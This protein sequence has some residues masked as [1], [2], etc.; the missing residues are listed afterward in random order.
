MRP[1]KSENTNNDTNKETETMKP[2]AN[3]KKAVKE[4]NITFHTRLSKSY[5][6]DEPHMRPENIEAV[7]K[8]LKELK[9]ELK[10]TKMLDMGCGT[11]FMINIGKKLG[12]EE[13]HGYDITPAMIE[14][15]DKSGPAKIVTGLSDAASLPC[16]DESFDIATAYAFF[17]HLDEIKSVIHEAHRCL[18]KNGALYADLDPN[19][20][21]WDAVNGLDPKEHF[22][23]FVAREITHVSYKDD[24][25]QKQYGVDKEIFNLAEYQKNI[26]GGMKEETIRQYLLE[27]GFK[28]VKF[29]YK[30]FI[31]QGN[32]NNDPDL[33]APQRQ[34]LMR[35]IDQYLQD[36]LPLSR[37]LYKYISFVAYK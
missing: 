32:I 17:H 5:N 7:T 36:T 6:V 25:I 29:N 21:L 27:A 37:N 34:D 22:H 18:R 13:I 14:Q 23:P 2:D 24:E 9:S 12:F 28:K 1:S 4:A 11:G 26:L 33:T 31:G 3:L 35:K 10:A 30:W 16:K 19:Y 8:N 20:Y 15:V